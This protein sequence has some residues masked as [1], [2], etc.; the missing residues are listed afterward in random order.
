[1]E[2]KQVSEIVNVALTSSLGGSEVSTAPDLSNVVDVGDTIQNIAQGDHFFEKFTNA[3]V[4]KIG[5]TIITNRSYTGNAPSILMDG[6]EYGSIMEKIGSEM[7]TVTK[8]DTWDLQDGQSYDPHVFHSA[9]AYSKYFNK[10]ITF[11]IDRSILDR[12]IRQSFQSAS[13]LNAF[14]SMLFNETQKTLTVA[15][16]QLILDTIGNLTAVTLANKAAKP[17]MA[18]N[19]LETYTALTG[20]AAPKA[21]VAIFDPDFVRH[22]AYMLKTYSKKLS[23]LTTIFNQGGK[24]RFTP[25]SM[26]KL[27]TLNDFM[28]A[29]DIYLQSDTYHEEYTRLLHGETVP[30]WQAPGEKFDWVSASTINFKPLKEDN[31][32]GEDVKQSGILAVMFDRD[33]CGVANFDQRVNTEWNP[34]GEFTNYFYKQD[35]RYFNDFNE[36]CVVFYVADASEAV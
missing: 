16:E 14:I 32:Q 36:Q 24:Q 31:T 28:Q 9:K 13:K 6:W 12:Q 35:A 15:N 26:L 11:E 20:K 18:V 34:K 8:N 2:V 33:A 19:L 27:I 21:N 17:A 23:A 29:A 10:M 22:A 30:Y 7:P 5:K 3:V 25:S 1:M 4:N